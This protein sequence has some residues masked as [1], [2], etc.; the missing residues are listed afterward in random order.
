ML[1]SIEINFYCGQIMNY[2]FRNWG[3]QTVSEIKHVE[4]YSEK[5]VHANIEDESSETH[6][7][8]NILYK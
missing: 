1:Y 2:R 3:L 8:S 4:N 7:P 5:L 6:Y